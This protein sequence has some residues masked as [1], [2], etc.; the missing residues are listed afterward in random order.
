MSGILDHPGLG[1][2]KPLHK[3]FLGKTLNAPIGS[4]VNHFSPVSTNISPSESG[5]NS[6]I[7]NLNN[8]ILPAHLTPSDPFYNRWSMLGRN[9][10]KGG[11]SSRKNLRKLKR[12][13]KKTRKT[14]N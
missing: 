7:N 9:P 3:K 1:L 12:K 8:T 2:N 4:V 5:R 6:P 14:R 13:Q 10:K 11:R